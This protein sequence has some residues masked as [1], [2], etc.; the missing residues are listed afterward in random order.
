MD[1]N[2][3]NW[4][5]I[6]G[7]DESRFWSS[8]AGAYVEVLPEDAGVTRIASEAELN[9]VLAVY[10]LPGPLVTVAMVKVEAARRIEAIMPDYKQRNVMAW[11]LETMMAHG[12]DPANWPPEL[13]AVNDA[14]QT[15][16]AAIKAIRARSDEIEAMEPIPADFRNDA[17][18]Q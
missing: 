7:G 1:F 18:W 13:Q 3:H 6:I 2:P 10:G 12:P 17:Y 8:A 15:A 16:W 4:F 11:G 5:W 9:D 14:A